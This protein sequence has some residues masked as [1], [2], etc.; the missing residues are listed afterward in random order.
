MHKKKTRSKNKFINITSIN[1]LFYPFFRLISYLLYYVVVRFF[2]QLINIWF[3]KNET[4]FGF[5]MNIEVKKNKQQTLKINKNKI[6][7]I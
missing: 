3:A 7:I 2:Y 4:S 5:Y 6:K 1:I